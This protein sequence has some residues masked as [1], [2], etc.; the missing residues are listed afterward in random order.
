LL[1]VLVSGLGAG[2]GHGDA[3][4]RVA[5]RVTAP[6][7]ASIVR[8]RSVEVRGRVQPSGA[9]VLVA[10]RPATVSGHRFRAT[11]P[12]RSGSNVVDLGASTQGA[13][14]TWTAVRVTRQIVVTVPDLVGT[15]RDEAAGRLGAL[16]LRAKIDERHRFFDVLDPSAWSVCQTGPRAGTTVPKGAVVRVIAS[17]GC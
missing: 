4:H 7:G 3:P 15:P 2:C 14:T 5:L 6:A 8:D 9:R 12:L 17:K 10:G 11:V 16:G 1:L 13:R